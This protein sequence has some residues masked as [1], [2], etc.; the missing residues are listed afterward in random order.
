M[1]AFCRTVDDLVDLANPRDGS[2]ALERLRA[3]HA[4]RSAVEAALGEPP[5]GREPPADPV[6]RELAWAVRRFGIPTRAI[7]ELLRGVGRDLVPTTYPDWD[8][9]ASYAEGVAS[10]VGEMC[11]TVFGVPDAEHRQ[12]AVRQA[13][14][15]GVA[16]QLTNIL[17][18]VGEDAR[19]GRCYLPQEDLAAFGFTVQDVIAGDVRDRWVQ[20]RA[21]MAF[22]VARARALYREALPGIALLHPDAQRCAVACASGYAS[23]LTALERLDY[24]CFARRAVV[25]RTALLVVMARAWLRRPGLSA[26]PSVGVPRPWARHQ[27]PLRGP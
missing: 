21:L 11:A 16:M 22:E 2:Q 13:R 8:A 27:A 3:Y 12:S 4:Y 26:R 15:L 17:R 1:Y 5:E 18:D 19:R 6:L 23:I 25:P 24:D 14:T 9:L 10:S 20:W 7:R